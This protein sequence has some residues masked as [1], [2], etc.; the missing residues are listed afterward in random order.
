MAITLGSASGIVSLDTSGVA[1][2][3]Q[4]A[5]GNLGSLTDNLQK[6]GGMMTGIGVGMSAAIT[7]PVTLAVKS[8]I[9]DAEDLQ[10][11]M[12]KTKTVFGDN[13]GGI[14]DW[15]N[16][17]AGSFGLS[18]QAAEDGADTFQ[19]ADK[20]QQI[21]TR[22]GIRSDGIQAHPEQGRSDQERDKRNRDSAC[23]Q[24]SQDKP[25]MGQIRKTK[26]EKNQGIDEGPMNYFI[27]ALFVFTIFILPGVS[28]IFS[29]SSLA[30][31]PSIF[32]A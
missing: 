7:V 27:G 3:V 12:G 15:A 10:D 17:A 30:I 25:M 21:H 31:S 5:I 14:E 18:K 1:S 9:E 19:Q 8:A 20:G 28:S 26:Q 32:S 11:T 4:S 23:R 16:T 6:V 22:Q 24:P 13:A 2:G 29:A